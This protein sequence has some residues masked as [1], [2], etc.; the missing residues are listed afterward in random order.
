[1]K[2]KVVKTKRVSIKGL[3]VELQ[4]TK[5]EK[6]FKQLY[7]LVKPAVINYFKQYPGNT[8]EKIEDAYNNA[9]ISIWNSIDKL[10]VKKYSISTMIF[11]KVKQEFCA[12]DKINHFKVEKAG[13][14]ISRYT[15]S[16]SVSG[17]SDDSSDKED[18]LFKYAQDDLTE[19]FENMFLEKEKVDCF[20]EDV[21]NLV[22]EGSTYS[23]F[24]DIV[25][26]DL[27]TKEVCAKYDINE[28]IVANRI[29]QVKK[30]IKNNKEIFK[31]YI[32]EV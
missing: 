26:G 23:I 1:M 6:V 15:S 31:G 28:Q 30:K 20:W 24:Y 9:M 18:S 8:I 14:S 29:F 4:N 3:G 5:S 13:T 32:Y 12:Y 7:D 16:S 17:S 22:G 11:L 2:Q 25:C 21:K 19:N 10:D 27:S